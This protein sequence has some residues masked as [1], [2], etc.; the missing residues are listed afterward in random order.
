MYERE[1]E[2]GQRASITL[3]FHHLQISATAFRETGA[4]ANHSLLCSFL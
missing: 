1:R 3:Q 2:R 4:A